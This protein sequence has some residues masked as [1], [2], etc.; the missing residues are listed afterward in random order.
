MSVSDFLGYARGRRYGRPSE[1]AMLRGWQACLDS[2]PKVEIAVPAGLLTDQSIAGWVRDY[3]I[4]IDVRS[5]PDMVVAVAAGVHPSRMTVHADCL[6]G[7]QLC[8]IV[9]RGAGR[10]VLSS[11]RQ[12]DLV[13]SAGLSR[14]QAVAT[15]LTDATAHTDREIQSIVDGLRPNIVGVHGDIGSPGFCSHREAIGYLLAEMTL[16][17]RRHGVVLGRLGLG[18]GSADPSGGS[19]SALA[20]LAADVEDA[21]DEACATLR[22]PRPLVALAPGAAPLSDGA[23]EEKC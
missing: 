15:R 19:A 22:Y 21:L 11:V 8:A 20:E 4:A 23:S 16:I 3:R 5:E 17:G 1:S 2:R 9:T 6:D 10:V 13:A 7:P 12:A 18:G 14:R